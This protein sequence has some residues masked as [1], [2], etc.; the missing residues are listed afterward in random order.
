MGDAGCDNVWIN[1]YIISDFTK[2][3]VDG[4]VSPDI[5]KVLI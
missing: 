4:T 2:I 3:V 5:L 1:V